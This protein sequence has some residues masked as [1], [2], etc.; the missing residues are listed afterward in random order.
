M[1]KLE[2]LNQRGQKTKLSSPMSNFRTRISPTCAIQYFLKKPEYSN[3]HQE[4]LQGY[5]MYMYMYFKVV[6]Y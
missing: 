2:N 4:F 6:S 5:Y 1:K 3:N